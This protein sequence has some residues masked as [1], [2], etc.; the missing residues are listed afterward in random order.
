[1]SALFPLIRPARPPRVTAITYRGCRGDLGVVPVPRAQW[2]TQGLDECAHTR[3]HLMLPSIVQLYS[4]KCKRL[5][6]H[7]IGVELMTVVLSAD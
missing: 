6:A 5:G 2:C 3:W 1:M 7:A 4:F